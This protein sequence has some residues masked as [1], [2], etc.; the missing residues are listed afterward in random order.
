[1]AA[2]STLF[3]TK[4][5]NP[6]AWYASSVA[7]Q[8]K[9][10]QEVWDGSGTKADGEFDESD[11]ESEAEPTPE[12]VDAAGAPVVIH[13]AVIAAPKPVKTVYLCRLSTGETFTK[14]QTINIPQSWSKSNPDLELAIKHNL[15]VGKRNK[16]A[17]SKKRRDAMAKLNDETARKK[18]SEKAAS[19]AARDAAFARRVVEMQKAAK[20]TV[21]IPAV[22]S[23]KKSSTTKAS[24][25]PFAVLGEDDDDDE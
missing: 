23:A 20:L 11:A 19:D 5:G 9:G 13:D 16:A 2:V 4:L 7:A 15:Y 14:D 10:T 22:A 1:M 6:D 21:P 3:P 17:L 25:N 8:L 12:I 24:S 18:A